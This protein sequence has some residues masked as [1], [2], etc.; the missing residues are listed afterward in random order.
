[1]LHGA[2]LRG[3]SK[4]RPAG[5]GWQWSTKI[6][7]LTR[8]LAIT[9]SGD[10]T[11][12]LWCAT[13][14]KELYEYK[15]KHVVKSVD[16]SNDS[17]RFVT[18]CQDGILRIYN[19]INPEIPPI[20][21]NHSSILSTTGVAAV[22]PISRVHWGDKN[23]NDVVVV[24][25]RSGFMELWDLRCSNTSNI[26]M[27]S[28]KPTITQQIMKDCSIID[29]EL[30][31]IHSSNNS[32]NNIWIAAGKQVS[33]LSKDL[34]VLKSYTMPDTMNFNEE[35]GVSVHPNGLTFMAVLLLFT[36]IYT[37]LLT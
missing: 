6:D 30:S 17:E 20:M 29:I 13:T 12:K 8:T 31:N 18:G 27:N 10:F 24:G 11:A 2:G 5:L 37:V 7:H 4:S 19:T 32:S 22:D 1:M 15:H 21:L 34:T 23:C 35:G 16:F 28:S 33:V 9:G 14:G 3:W 26:D 25:R 36:I